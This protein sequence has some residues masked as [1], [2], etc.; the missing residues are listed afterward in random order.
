MAAAAAPAPA[1]AAAVKPAGSPHPSASLYVGDLAP[2]CTG[3]SFVHIA[4]MPRLLLQFLHFFIFR[5][6]PRLTFFFVPFLGALLIFSP[7]ETRLFELFNQV[8]P[9]A[10]IRVCRDAITRR[11]LGYAYV[12]FHSVVDGSSTFHISFPRIDVL[13]CFASRNLTKPGLAL[14]FLRSGVFAS[15]LPV[16]LF[17]CRLLSLL[18]MFFVVYGFVSF[19]QIYSAPY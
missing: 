12:N 14:A 10:S 1:P 6:S 17:L 3:T 8:G 19:V 9:V 4:F 16:S 13:F 7:P 5:S 18:G 2:E 11:S 15:F